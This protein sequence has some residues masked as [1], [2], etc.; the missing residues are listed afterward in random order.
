MQALTFK[1]D[2]QFLDDC[3]IY[4]ELTGRKLHSQLFCSPPRS[5]SFAGSDFQCNTHI[6][7][8]KNEE[9]VVMMFILNFEYVVDEE[10]DNS[11]EKISPTSPTKSDQ[12]EYLKGSSHLKIRILKSNVPNFFSPPTPVFLST[13]IRNLHQPYQTILPVFAQDVLHSVQPSLQNPR[14]EMRVA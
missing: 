2:Q 11:T 7:P 10:S 13:L 3:L 8:V 4:R 5:V 12:S 9:G 1:P 6:I 14:K